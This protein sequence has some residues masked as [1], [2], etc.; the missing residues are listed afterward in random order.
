MKEKLLWLQNYLKETYDTPILENFLG[1][2]VSA[3]EEGKIV[4]TAKIVDRHCN[5]YGFI[6][7]GTLASVSDIAMGVACI[8]LG[9]KVVT[10]DMNISYIKNAPAGSIITAIGQVVG[11]GRTIMRATGEIY[12][13]QQL[14][15][16]SQASYFV[17]GEF[18]EGR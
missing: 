11:N 12:C 17:T 7:G 13:E 4:Y 16:R 10:I 3:L 18:G 2:E 14:L 1:L 9:K 5:M 6:H 8:T 15:V